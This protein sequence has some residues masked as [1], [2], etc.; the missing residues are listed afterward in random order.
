MTWQVNLSQHHGLC[1]FK[2]AAAGIPFGLLFGVIAVVT[3]VIA[4]GAS[5]R[6][7]KFAAYLFGMIALS[8]GVTSLGLLGFYLVGGKS[9]IQSSLPAL[10]S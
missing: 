6:D 9:H 3:G 4:S 7:I 8:A 2:W 10:T 1:L 5:S